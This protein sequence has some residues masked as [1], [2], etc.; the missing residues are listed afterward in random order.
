MRRAFAALTATLALATS[1]F[2]QTSEP[3]ISNVRQLTTDDQ[4]AGEAYFSPDGKRLLFQAVRDGHPYYQIYVMNVDGTG[5]RMVSTGKG[6]TTCAYFHPTDPDLFVYASSHLDERTHA[7]PPAGAAQGRGYRWDYDGSMDVFLARVSTGEIVQRLTTADGYDAECAFSPDGRSICFT[8]QRGG[9]DSDIWLMDADGSNQRPVIQVKGTD[10][11]PFFSPDGRSI[12]FRASRER[13]DVM[14]CYLTSLDGKDVRQLTEQ[15]RVNWAPFFHPNGQVVVYT[16]NVGGHRNYDLFLVKADGSKREV[17]LTTDEQFDGLPTFSPDGTKL[18]WTSSRQGG[19][20]QVF[21]ADFAMPPEA[22]FAVPAAPEANPHGGGQTNPHGGQTNPHGGGQTNPHGGGQ[23]NP[24]GG[25]TNP[26]Q[27]NPHGDQGASPHGSNPHGSDPHAAAVDPIVKPRGPASLAGADRVRADAL[28]RDITWLADDARDGRGAGTP[29]ERAAA[30][31]LAGR[32]KELGVRP[33]GTDGAWLEP[34]AFPAGGVFDDARVSLAVDSVPGFSKSPLVMLE[35]QTE[36]RPLF[37][38]ASGTVE[39]DLVFCGY[40]ITSSDNHY[41]DYAG[42]DARGKIAVVLTGGPNSSTGGAFGKEHPTVF[43][44]LQYKV[45]NAREHGASAVLF[46]KTG[47][48]RSPE[49]EWLRLDMGDPGVVVGQVSRA[50]A[51]E[52]GLDVEATV[53]RIEKE[54]APQSR[55]LGRKARL[56]VTIE[57]RR[58]R[59]Q[60]V[61]GRITGTTQPQDVIVVGAHYDHLGRGGHGSLAGDSS[62]VHNGADDNASGT[63]ALLALA[64][65]LRAAPPRRTVLLVAFGAEEQGLLGSQAFVERMPVSRERVVAMINMD[66]IGRLRDQPLL[67]GGAGSAEEWPAIIQGAADATG[68][69]LR[70]QQDGMGPSDHAT[71]YG[72]GVPV[73]FLWTGTHDD[74]HK[75]SDDAHLI[76]APGVERCAK[77]ALALLRGVD[78]LERRPTFVKVSVAAQPRRVV[79]GERGAY[80]GSIPNYAQDGL[81]GVLLDGAREGTP[82]GRAGVQKGDVV[83]EFAGHEVRTIQDYTNALR[84]SR[85]GQTVKVVVLRAGQRVELEA[86][87]EGRR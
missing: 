4:R 55:P 35:R 53:A 15:P 47:E 6:K 79:T 34:F 10:G 13:D 85:P 25:Q 62:E 38:S 54:L 26:H 17:R 18:M 8:S 16:A 40:G 3:F 80:F 23:T 87:L 65:A 49:D 74:Y 50:K 48:V 71:F 2:A 39:A 30:E 70:T 51:R 72:A 45:L 58:G 81:A 22:A 31:W 75:P 64:E 52:L 20:P 63:A 36:W 5:R 68:S 24:H 82:A 57:R 43:Q 7:A 14:Q 60:N 61:V 69:S 19:Q 29:A 32:M 46:V 42:Q 37:Y 1:A 28:L 11:G 41:D 78:A 77:V 66:M 33:G 83:V 76:D 27:S 86:T 59:S 12:L 84:L 44:D 21:I 67:V 9:S 73:F 56:Q